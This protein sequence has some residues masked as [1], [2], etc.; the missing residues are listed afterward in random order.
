MKNAKKALA[1]VL[2]LWMLALCAVPVLAEGTEYEYTPETCPGH[3]FTAVT[4]DPTCGAQGYTSHV[5]SRCGFTY[6]NEFV[7]ATGEHDWQTVIDQPAT[8]GAAGVKQVK[9]NTCGL[10]QTTN[11]PATGN[12]TWV[13]ETEKYHAPT[14]ARPGERYYLCSGCGKEYS[15]DTDELEEPRP[16]HVDNNKDN[17]C[18][19][20]GQSVPSE[21]PSSGMSFMNVWDRFFGFFWNLIQKIG[22]LF[23]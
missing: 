9:C 22:A 12:H 8:C 4:V 18:D 10:V 23:N 15:Q 14:C 17:I 7:D 13:E 19:N 16:A 3:S 11:T 20:C 5:C 6:N 21:G 1:V 2:S